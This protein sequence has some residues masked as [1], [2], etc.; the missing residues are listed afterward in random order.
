MVK[1]SINK[2]GI[3]VDIDEEA[4]IQRNKRMGKNILFTSREDEIIGWV[5]KNYKEKDVIENGFKMMKDF[6]LVRIQPIRHWTDTKIRAFIFCAVIS[7]LLMKIMLIKLE[8][9]DLKMSARILKEE[10]GDLKEIIM[11]HSDQSAEKKI[12]QMSSVQKQVAALFGV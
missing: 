6:D 12:S 8:E 10:L 2:N 4:I 9:A 11:I 7:Y 1:V 3:V 5:I